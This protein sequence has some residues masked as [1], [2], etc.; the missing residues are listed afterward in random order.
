MQRGRAK[1][2]AGARVPPPIKISIFYTTFAHA[3]M[4]GMIFPTCTL[5]IHSC[6]AFRSP[7]YPSFFRWS[8]FHNLEPGECFFWKRPLRKTSL[9]FVGRDRTTFSSLPRWQP[10]FRDLNLGVHV[11]QRKSA[12]PDSWNYVAAGDLKSKLTQEIPPQKQ[13]TP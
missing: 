13:T 10:D 11:S 4:P 12:P 3:G 2:S 9:H 6:P 5:L 8:T 1:W 7:Y